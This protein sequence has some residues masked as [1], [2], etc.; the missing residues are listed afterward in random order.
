MT[1]TKKELV[2]RIAER[3][4]ATKVTAKQ[5][6]QS[7]LDEIIEE[8]ARGNRLEFRDFGIFEVR[9]RRARRAQNPRT[10]EKVAVPPKRVVRFKA[11]RILRQRVGG[12]TD[13]GDDGPPDAG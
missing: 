5:V 9:E 6:I 12:G 4:R 8:L 7:F 2:D 3:A 11:G 13:P 10:L 1:V